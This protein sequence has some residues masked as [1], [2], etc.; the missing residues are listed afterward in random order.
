M[1]YILSYFLGLLLLYY[2]WPTEISLFLSLQKLERNNKMRW[3]IL[4]IPDSYF[5]N[6]SGAFVA[7]IAKQLLK[8]IGCTVAIYSDEITENQT[9][10][11]GVEI[12][13]RN[14]C[15]STANWFVSKYKAN[16]A[17]VLDDFKPN[18]IFTLGS[19]T[20]KNIIFWSMARKRG[21][22]IISK[23]FMQDFFCNNYYANDIWYIAPFRH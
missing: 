21:I 23:I 1:L 7:Q 10:A 5:G 20:N 11:D 8:E 16:Y 4:I 19:V 2:I 6:Y 3:K 22:K 13:Y 12:Y 9:E 15:S 17:K 18:P 14:K